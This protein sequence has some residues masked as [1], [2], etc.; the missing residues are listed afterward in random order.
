MKSHFC[1]LSLVA[2]LCTGQL[3]AQVT[4][5]PA[6]PADNGRI[7]LRSMIDSMT[8]TP[9]PPAQQ[10]QGQTDPAILPSLPVLER[11]AAEVDP[12]QA[13]A[14]DVAFYPA[15]SDLGA[16]VIRLSGEFA[17][18]NLVIDVPVVTDVQE[19]RIAYRT[20]IN[21][22]PELSSVTVLLNGREIAQFSP[23]SFEGFATVQ[24]PMEN[25]IE[26]QNQLMVQISQS[27]RIFC[28]PEA[29]FDIWTE[30]DLR[31]SGISVAAQTGIPDQAALRRAL[32]AQL[33]TG[34]PVYVVAAQ[35]PTQD[36]LAEL[37]LRLGGLTPQLTPKVVV[38]NPFAP[39]P[40][41]AGLARIAIID[42][43]GPDFQIRRARDGALVLVMRS[44]SD[45]DVLDSF[46]PRP[47]PITGPVR[48]VPGSDVTLAQMGLPPVAMR[49]RYGRS[50]LNFLLP[51]DWLLLASQ[52][53]EIGLIYDYA[54]GLPETALMLLKV[55]DTTVRLL[56]L[57]GQGGE[58][59]PV[60]Q[61]SF[62]ARLLSPGINALTVETIIPGEPPDMPCPRIEGE[63]LRVS[64]QT[65]LRIPA[66]PSMQ[67]PDLG[68]QLLRLAPENIAAVT[69]DT[70]ENVA[71][72][73][74]DALHVLFRP[75]AETA[76]TGSLAI[77]SV[78]H[79]DAVPLEQLGLTRQMVETMLVP[80]AM[81]TE[82]DTVA[83][84]RSLGA[85][86]I[87]FVG[88]T[89][90]AISGLARPRDPAL[91]DWVD[92]RHGDALLLMPDLQYRD[93]LWLVVA[94]GA[95]PERVAAAVTAGRISATGPSGQLSILTHDGTWQS[96][97]S[98]AQGPELLEP[99]SI[100]NVRTVAGNYAS[101]SPL[102][103]ATLMGALLILS[104]I[105]ALLFVVRNRGSRKR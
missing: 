49:G 40:T 15:L 19:L 21:V 64:D 60:L 14:A 30:I 81:M 17:E 32:I 75:L 2:L 34:E 8:P 77:T 79:A 103:Y 61:V 27:H 29:S 18:A 23:R 93:V 22:L 35:P 16:G 68:A 13:A 47:D 33:A 101:W 92:G 50:D 37:S 4:A 86:V 11:S 100:A 62:P 20:S 48:F 96:W 58:E 74:A 31:Q 94:Q 10:T 1:L 57:F 28:G 43:A 97:M 78:F 71:T 88:N 67:F 5:D 73:V 55:N 65:T 82:S 52:S 51:P 59:I 85:R 98:P 76:T 39:A 44:L 6:T 89:I 69:R 105:V 84:N 7:D 91:A 9:V 53:A 70:R 83:E 54:E 90:T 12:D 95:D 72:S 87:G 25:L 80:A 102:G 66:S 99:L 24:L 56:P 63:L 36:E 46:L 42:R 45:T 38:Q 26:G 41:N 3:Q 104:V